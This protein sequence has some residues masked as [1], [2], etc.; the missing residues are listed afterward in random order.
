MVRC[1]K[2]QELQETAGMDYL[3]AVNNSKDPL[4]ETESSLRVA[5]TAVKVA[6]IRASQTDLPFNREEKAHLQNPQTQIQINQSRSQSNKSNHELKSLKN[7]RVTVSLLSNLCNKQDL[8]R[9][10]PDPFLQELPQGPSERLL[11]QGNQSIAAS[12]D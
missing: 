5:R 3:V 11:K 8:V 1:P 12:E 9:F 7:P 4:K 10:A 2:S 6:L